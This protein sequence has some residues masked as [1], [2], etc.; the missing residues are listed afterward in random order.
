MRKQNRTKPVLIL[1]LKNENFFGDD[2][3]DDE[4]DSGG[5]EAG[6]GEGMQPICDLVGMEYG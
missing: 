5:A 6:K 3:G 2:T 1:L 4:H